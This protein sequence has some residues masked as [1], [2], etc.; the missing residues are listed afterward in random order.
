MV[1]FR[2]FFRFFMHKL[3]MKKKTTRR[4][5]ENRDSVLDYSA[6]PPTG[7]ISRKMSTIISVAELISADKSEHSIS[8][9]ENFVRRLSTND[10]VFDL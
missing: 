2:G 9:V 3:F 8:S 6:P 1:Q 7:K 5:V 4:R 10:D